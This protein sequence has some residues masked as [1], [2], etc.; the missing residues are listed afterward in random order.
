[1]GIK[2]YIYI[3]ENLSHIYMVFHIF[4]NYMGMVFHS[5]SWDYICWKVRPKC[6]AYAKDWQS[7]ITFNT[8]NWIVINI[9]DVI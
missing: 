3:F 6:K 4:L 5:E 7:H 9:I 8:S 2:K 1:M